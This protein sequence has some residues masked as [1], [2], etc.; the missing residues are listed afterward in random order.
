[1]EK[2]KSTYIPERYWRA[3]KNN[4]STYNGLFYYGVQTT[5]IF[6]RPSCKSRLPLPENVQIFS[7]AKEALAKQFRPCK[8]C[9]PE[10]LL[11]PE[12]KWVE[13]LIDWIDC[14]LQRKITLEDL[15]EVVH[16]SPYHLQRT[17]KKRTGKSP[18]VYIR[19]ARVERA[20][21]YLVSTDKSISS[22]SKE[23]GV[24][25][26]AYFITIFKDSMNVTPTIYRA[27]QQGR[28]NLC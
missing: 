5:G 14:H 13:E 6:C 12:D 15:A 10:Q 18:H 11:L 26:T 17:F 3:I 8:R 28:G 9:R 25:N 7:S 4:D 22:I 1:M 27:R 23:V 19:N 24:E 21:E 16:V 20:K 2:Q